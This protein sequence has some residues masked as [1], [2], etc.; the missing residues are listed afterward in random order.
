MF[1]NSKKAFYFRGDGNELHIP[2]NYLGDFPDWATKTDLFALAVKGGDIV[3]VNSTPIVPVS[4]A[5][6]SG[7]KTRAK[8]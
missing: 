4:D 6:N 5:D 8:N 2:S 3:A 1:I 7:K